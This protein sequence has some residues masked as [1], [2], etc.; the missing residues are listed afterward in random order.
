MDVTERKLVAV[1]DIQ[2]MVR[3]Y[4]TRITTFIEAIKLKNDESR[5]ESEVASF[6]IFLQ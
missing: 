2:P 6:F 1:R 5:K 3:Y 4:L